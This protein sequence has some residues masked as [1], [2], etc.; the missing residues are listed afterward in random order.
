MGGADWWPLP[1]KTK[2]EH[3]EAKAA[4]V[5]YFGRQTVSGIAEAV[6]RGPHRGN[7]LFM[8]SCYQH[9]ANLCIGQHHGSIVNGLSF[10]TCSWTI[11]MLEWEPTTPATHCA[12]APFEPWCE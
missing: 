12:I 1:D 9:G 6:M 11:A 2:Q 8:P 7:G 4:Y 10:H 5:R 3:A